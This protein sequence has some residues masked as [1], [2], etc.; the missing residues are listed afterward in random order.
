MRVAAV[1]DEDVVVNVLVLPDGKA[2]DALL[3]DND[4]WIELT[5]PEAGIGWRYSDGEFFYVMSDEE[6]AAQALL[7]ERKRQR[8]A[9]L[10]R[11]GL[12]EDEANLLLG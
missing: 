6:L 5:H 10:D 3:K 2:G 1:I 9:I 7:D 12:T 11:L 8:A 4:S